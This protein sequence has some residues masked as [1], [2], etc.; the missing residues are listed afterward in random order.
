M[1]S[2][3]FFAETLHKHRAAELQETARI[4]RFLQEIKKRD[5]MEWQQRRLHRNRKF[6]N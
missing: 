2:M 4:E 3:T 6:R 5:S 1:D